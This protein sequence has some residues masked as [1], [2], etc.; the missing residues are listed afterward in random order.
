MFPVVKTK[1]AGSVWGTPLRGPRSI[2]LR[3]TGS[4]PRPIRVT[5]PVPSLPGRRRPPAAGRTW[6]G[7]GATRHARQAG[8]GTAYRRPAA[9]AAPPFI[10]R[11]AAEWALAARLFPRR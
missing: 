4:A 11:P 1:T 3:G 9:T 10:C 5:I 6:G 7:R 2:P 8:V